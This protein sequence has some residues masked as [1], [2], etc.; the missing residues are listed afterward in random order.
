MIVLLQPRCPIDGKSTSRK[1]C[2][3]G[4]QCLSL[5]HCY[6][7]LSLW[8]INKLFRRCGPNF[9]HP[10]QG[11]VRYRSSIRGSEISVNVPGVCVRWEE[12]WIREQM[13]V[14]VIAASPESVP[15]RGLIVPRYPRKRAA[16]RNV[17]K[18]V[19]R[20]CLEPGG[21][22]VRFRDSPKIIVCVVACLNICRVEGICNRE[23]L[24]RPIWIP[25]EISVCGSSI[26]D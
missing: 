7:L 13:P 5:H 9:H 25:G 14:T 21:S 18:W 4:C 11:V 2:V 1:R 8:G 16:F 17:S 10:S 22:A 12:G 3:S 15:I 6:W 19:V 20:K 23:L 24:E 26:Y